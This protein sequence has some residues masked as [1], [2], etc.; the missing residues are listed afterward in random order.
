MEIKIKEGHHY[1]W[2]RSE[3]IS[4]I[5]QKNLEEKKVFLELYTYSNENQQPRIVSCAFSKRE[6]R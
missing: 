4:G 5:S 2:T 6:F 1:Y 3:P